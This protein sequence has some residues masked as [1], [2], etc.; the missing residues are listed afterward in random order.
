MV[1]ASIP[2]V[3]LLA[4]VPAARAGD[5][6]G[7]VIVLDAVGPSPGGPGTAAN[8]PRFVLLED[9][10]VFVG[11]T[12]RLATGR[13]ERDEVKELEKRIARVR[14]IPGLGSQV[15]FGA[16]ASPRYHL[17]LGKGQPLD[18]LAT[19][20]PASAPAGLRPLASL[21]QDLAAF[22]H[23]SLRSY[24]PAAY[25]LSA[26]EGALIGG[27]RSWGFAVPLAEALAGPRSVSA[28]AVADWPTGGAPASVCAGDK[29]Y[30]VTLRPLLPGEKP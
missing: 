29:R 27:C 30:V 26:R 8:S 19:G 17:R 24:E 18:I 9:G 22:A 25:A 2:L 21:V 7:A 14:K 10:Q 4:L 16:A 15:S 23:E 3:A 28:A 11:G 12:Q 20:D 1:R 5:V 6:P 13:L